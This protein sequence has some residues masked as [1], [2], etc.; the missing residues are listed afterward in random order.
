MD[1]LGDQGAPGSRRAVLWAMTGRQHE[2]LLDLDGDEV[3]VHLRVVLRGGV[4]LCQIPWTVLPCCCNLRRF[5]CQY[6]RRAHIVGLLVVSCVDHLGHVVGVAL[7]ALRLLS[8]A[9]VAQEMRAGSGAL[10]LL[11]RIYELLG[12]RRNNPWFLDGDPV[13]RG[14]AEGAAVWKLILLSPNS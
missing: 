1:P 10:V 3:V 8:G 11:Q 12:R 7:G 9:R 6:K 5:R 4:L 2:H 13:L 14:Q